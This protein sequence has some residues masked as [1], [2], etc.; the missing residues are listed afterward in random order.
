MPPSMKPYELAGLIT[1]CTSKFKIEPGITVT[2]SYFPQ[3]SFHADVNFSST[4][5]KNIF[6]LGSTFVLLVNDRF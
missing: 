6:M 3:N 2:K 1:H 5:D 4:D